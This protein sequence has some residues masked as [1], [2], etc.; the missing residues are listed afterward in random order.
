M[1]KRT[2]PID[3]ALPHRL[4]LPLQALELG[5]LALQK[6]FASAHEW[7]RGPHIFGGL[8]LSALA[9]MWFPREEHNN[10]LFDLFKK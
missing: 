5:C 6:E 2:D 10:I 3:T 4:Q 8:N 9:Q 1:A 7:E